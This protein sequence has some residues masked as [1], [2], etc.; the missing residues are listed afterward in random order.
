MPE[1]SSVQLLVGGLGK[2]L[3]MFKKLWVEEI[4]IQ[5]GR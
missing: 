4:E 2:K 5:Q 1:M 3:L